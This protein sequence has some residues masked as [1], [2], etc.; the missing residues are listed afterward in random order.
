MKAD[1][2]TERQ[3]SPRSACCLQN[4]YRSES[5][6]SFKKPRS[7]VSFLRLSSDSPTF[8]TAPTRGEP[9]SWQTWS[10]A[11]HCA[12]QSPAAA[13]HRSWCRTGPNQC[14][15]K[16]PPLQA[17]G[18]AGKFLSPDLLLFKPEN[19][20]KMKTVTI[21]DYFSKAKLLPRSSKNG[22]RQQLKFFTIQGQ[23]RQVQN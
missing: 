14:C 3:R 12:K 23:Q 15:G 5:K 18:L 11:L 10:S 8:L 17:A 9:C 21:N 6:Q 20:V 13:A 16:G 4:H 1:V 2:T 19:T 22:Q 7:E